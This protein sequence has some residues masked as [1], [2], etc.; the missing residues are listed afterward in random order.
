MDKP[1]EFGGHLA[2]PKKVIEPPKDLAP[3]Q[4]FRRQSQARLSV[5]QEHQRST[6][7]SRSLDHVSENDGASINSSN[8]QLSLQL[9]PRTEDDADEDAEQ[10]IQEI[11][12]PGCHAVG[13]N[14]PKLTNDIDHV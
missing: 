4:R 13:L 1:T 11:W 7:P 9:P 2:I 8:S 12:F 6:N 10:D 5:S 3:N 14:K